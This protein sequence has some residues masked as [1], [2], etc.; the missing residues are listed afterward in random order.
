MEMYLLKSAA[1]LAVLLVFYKLALERSSMHQLKRIYLL[2]TLALPFVIPAIT[3][4]SYVQTMETSGT[5]PLTVSNI[6]GADASY[7]IPWTEILWTIYLCGAGLFGI[8][9]T[10]RLSRIISRIR[11]NPRERYHNIIKVLLPQKVVPHTFLSYIFLNMESDKKKDIPTAVLEHE[12]VHAQEMHSLDVLLVEL[13]K[14]VLWFNPLFIWLGNSIKLNHEF[15]A[16]SS[17]LKKGYAA[18]NYQETILAYSSHAMVPAMAHSINYSSLKKRFTV[19]RT[20]SS[21]TGVWLRS[22][23]LLPLLALT[24]YSFSGRETITL[25]MEETVEE[26]FQQTSATREEKKE[27]NK[28]ARKYNAMKKE[29]RIVKLKDLKRLEFIYQKMSDK[30]RADAEPFP[31]CI[32]PPPPPPPPPPGADPDSPDAPKVVGSVPPP[33]PPPDAPDPMENFEDMVNKG[34][35]FYLNGKEISKKQAMELENEVSDLKTIRVVRDDSG[36]NVIYFE[37]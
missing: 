24:L 26:V 30:Q 12:R 34:Q 5:N 1:C 23:L 27:Y 35:S 7:S 28:L 18:S 2:A 13:A 4:T 22:L 3:F 19:M 37:N 11:R 9:F 36:K 16:D 8:R 31:E 6:L 32:P 20:K 33:P 25:P 17:V 14:V 21:R 15:L 10:Y 29:E